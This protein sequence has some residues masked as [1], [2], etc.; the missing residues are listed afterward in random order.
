MRAFSTT[1]ADQTFE[2][3]GR[4]RLHS[5]PVLECSQTRQPS[6]FGSGRFGVDFRR[7]Y[8]RFDQ[9]WIPRP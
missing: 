3:G 8:M 5:R 4:P 2:L 7:G 1:G 6:P 9:D